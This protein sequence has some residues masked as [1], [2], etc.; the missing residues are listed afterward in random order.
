MSNS[1]H[2]LCEELCALAGVA[3]P[4]MSEQPNGILA[5]NIIWRDVTVN[6]VHRPSP[7]STHAFVMFDM[8]V[9][10]FAQANPTSV[11]LAL[12][13]A[14]FMSLSPNQPVFSCHPETGGT[15]LQWA[16]PLEH[17]TPDTL[18]QV[19]KEGVTLVLDWRETHF[20]PPRDGSPSVVARTALNENFA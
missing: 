4:E 10:D 14:N 15:M 1:F 17:A 12:M 13:Q 3:A 18:L 9:P 5:L 8:G 16:L 19:V 2:Q 11:L 20:L 6:V 7:T